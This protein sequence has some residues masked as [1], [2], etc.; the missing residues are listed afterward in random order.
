MG[1]DVQTLLVPT[2]CLAVFVVITLF[3]GAY[4]NDLLSAMY[5]KNSKNKTWIWNIQL[6]NSG[7]LYLNNR[8]YL[9]EY[10][11]DT[12]KFIGDPAH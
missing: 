2:M 1:P 3:L 4:L 8:V 7:V 11:L 10:I 6:K 5:G 9:L 12:R